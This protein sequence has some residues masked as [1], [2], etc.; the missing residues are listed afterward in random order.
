MIPCTFYKALIT[1]NYL[2]R[3]NKPEIL[4]VAFLSFDCYLRLGQLMK[5]NIQYISIGDS[6]DK[7]V[8]LVLKTIK[9]GTNPSFD[10]RY[11]LVRVLLLIHIGS[12]ENPKHQE[13][14]QFTG[15]AL[16]Q[17][18]R[19]IMSNKCELTDAR[20]HITPHSFRRAGSTRNETVCTYVQGNNA[21]AVQ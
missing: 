14:F 10:I 17:K 13:I 20:H 11:E 9:S 1:S 21:V 19:T 3:A 2:R 15:S 6:P 7:T 16:K 18:I 5:L 12:F 4:F 8:Y